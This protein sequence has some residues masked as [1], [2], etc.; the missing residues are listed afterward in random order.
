M[1]TAASGN[2]AYWRAACGAALGR[3]RIYRVQPQGNEHT[4][5]PDD[6][7]LLT[8]PTGDITRGNVVV[9]PAPGRFDSGDGFRFLDRV[10]GLPGQTV[11]LQ[12]GRVLVDGEALDEPYVYP[13]DRTEPA[14]E[15]GTSSWTVGVGQLFVLADRRS[16]S[17]DSRVFGPIPAASVQDVARYRCGPGGRAGPIR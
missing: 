7:L 15:D 9:F 13:N 14:A 12:D 10:I 5:E 1:P 6:L 16:N 8:P 17:V 3:N 2:T 4:F 11:T